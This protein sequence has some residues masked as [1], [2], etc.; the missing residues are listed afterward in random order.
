MKCPYCAVNIHFEATGESV[1]RDGE[2]PEDT[3]CLMH[4]FCPHCERLIV[5]LEHGTYAQGN[6][7]S[8]TVENVHT[9][10]ILYPKAC[11]REPLPAE[12]PEECRKDF[13]EAA[14]VLAISPKASAAISRRLLQQLLQGHFKITAGSLA[15]EIQA[16]VVLPDIPSHLSEAVDAVRN[17]GNLAAHPLKDQ[18]T[19][20]IVDVEPGEAEWLLDVLEAVFDFAFVQPKRLQERKKQLNAKLASL[21]KPPMRV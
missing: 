14:S 9:R 15:H 10:E 7:Y 18:N 21:G 17:V 8:E 20:A 12:V 13:V 6:G 1:I 16:F 4:G 19:G 3:A 2:N 11:A 5:L